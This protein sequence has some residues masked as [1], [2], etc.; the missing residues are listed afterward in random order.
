MS[1]NN[2]L[3]HSFD[4]VA[5]LYNEARSRYPDELFSTLIDVTGLNKDSKLLEIGPGTGQATMPLAKKGFDITAIE[6]GATLAEVAKYELRNYKNVQIST[7]VFEKITLSTKSLPCLQAYLLRQAASE[8][9][10]IRYIDE[11]GLYLLPL[12]SRTW[13]KQGQ[14]LQLKEQVNRAHTDGKAH[15]YA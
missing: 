10:T 11:A 7:G 12:L 1:K 15:P 5:L 9:K 14:T 8:N 4:E 13:A 2:S 3:R 6:L